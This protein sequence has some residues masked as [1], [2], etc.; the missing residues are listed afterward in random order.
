MCSLECY[1]QKGLHFGFEL[2]PVQ[3]LVNL[4][5]HS[6]SYTCTINWRCFTVVHA[7]EV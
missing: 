2:A 5:K 7:L 1:S 6:L 4:A 3:M